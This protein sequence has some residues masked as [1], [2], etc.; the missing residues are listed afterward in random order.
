M[1]LGNKNDIFKCNIFFF[2]LLLNYN[3]IFSF[4]WLRIDCLVPFDYVSDIS[5]CFHKK[6]S[7]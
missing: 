7:W 3:A 5:E 6:I 4:V 2:E 1:T